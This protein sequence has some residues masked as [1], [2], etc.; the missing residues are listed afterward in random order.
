MPA[1]SASETLFDQIVANGTPWIDNACDVNQSEN[2][3][4][5]FKSKEHPESPGAERNDF[6]LFAEALSGFANSEGG[7]LIWGVDARRPPGDPAAPDGA[8]DK[9]PIHSLARFKGDLEGQIA[10]LTSPPI[11]GVK[12]LPIMPDVSQDVGYLVT[13]VP[14]GENPP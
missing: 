10:Q 6:K 1:P 5:E 9:K 11:I 7:V 13:L 8:V 14:E 4:L 3:H 2:L 12:L